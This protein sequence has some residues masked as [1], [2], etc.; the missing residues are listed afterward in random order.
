MAMSSTCSWLVSR[1]PFVLL[2]CCAYLRCPLS[3]T[4]PRCC[5]AHQCSSPEQLVS[6]VPEKLM[7]ECWQS[8]D[9]VANN[10]STL[11]LLHTDLEAEAEVDADAKEKRKRAGSPQEGPG[12][13]E[14]C[15]KLASRPDARHFPPAPNTQSFS[16]HRVQG[17]LTPTGV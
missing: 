14:T 6:L 11:T 10:V 17:P 4:W 3:L 15:L 12:L 5:Y 7:H 8:M 16:V 1:P 13:E 9:R 2:F